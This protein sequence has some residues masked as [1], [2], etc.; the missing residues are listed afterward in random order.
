MIPLHD[1]IPSSRPPYVNYAIIAVNCVMFLGELST[2]PQLDKLLETFGFVPGRFLGLF[3][4]YGP[5][6]LP[7]MLIPL[8]T[9]LFL[10]AGWLHLIGNMWFLYIF[11]DNV[12]DVLATA[13]TSC[14][15]WCRE[16]GPT[17]SF[18]CPPPT[19]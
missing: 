13:A 14:S 12:E 19:P 4:T 11:G 2:G 3:F 9:S 16:W 1:N 10:H 15:T 8:F 17:S 18:S 6:A 7:V 5:L